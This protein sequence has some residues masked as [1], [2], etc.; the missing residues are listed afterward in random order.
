M[1][2]LGGISR[3]ESLLDFSGLSKETHTYHKRT[4][5]DSETY[6]K[7]T[8]E[9]D[10]QNRLLAQKHQVN[11][12]PVEPIVLNTYNEI[13][14]VINKKI[15][16]DDDG[17]PLQS[18]NYGYNIHGWL[19]SINDP[20]NM[21][22]DH[23]FAM[24]IKYQN[25]EDAN[26]G[27]A[28]YNGN[29]SEIDWK[30]ALGDGISRRYT[31]QYDYL[32]RL[33][34]GIYL[35]PG[36]TSNSNNH[37][38]DETVTY[39]LNGNIKTLNRYKN[40]PVGQTTPMQIDELVYDYDLGGNSNRLIKV[41]D[42]KMNPSGYPQGGNLISYDANGNMSNH[43][44]K[45]VKAI[46]YNYLN[47]ATSVNAI[48]GGFTPGMNEGT[49]HT[50]KYRADGSKYAK[51]VDNV[52]PYS[53]DYSETDYIDGFQYERTYSKMNTSQNASDS[54]YTLRSVPT[55]EGFYNFEREEYIYNL[56]DHL[57]NVRYNIARA[58]GG[59]RILME[60]TNYYPFGLKHEGYNNGS[61]LSQYGIKN[62]Y[63]YNGKELQETG[64]YDYG[65]RNYMPDLGRWGVI[66]PL[67]EKYQSFSPFNYTLNN[68]LN[69]ID[70][71]GRSVY[72]PRRGLN[73]YVDGDGIFRWNQGM[74]KY[75]HYANT[76][77]NPSV[78]NGFLGY[79][80][81]PETESSA[82]AN[83]MPASEGVVA[84]GNT[85]AV[86]SSPTVSQ[87]Q[88][89]RNLIPRSETLD[90][91]VNHP[92]TSPTMAGFGQATAKTSAR[93]IQS[94]DRAGKI[95]RELWWGPKF[96]GTFRTST[97]WASRLATTVNFTGNAVGVAGLG[98]TS[99]QYLSGQITGTEAFFDGGV[100]VLSFWCPAC[101]LIY[102]GGK[103]LYEQTTGRPAF[104]KPPGIS[105]EI[106]PLFGQPF[107]FKY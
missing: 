29:I 67:S 106:T 60:E 50:Y 1:N 81:M 82:A 28:R 102:F 44:D 77:E 103:T 32:N 64:M 66:D 83:D 75:E 90:A 80:S 7:E 87:P 9:Y 88:K 36:L 105:N 51:R 63:K 35:T 19:T 69:L 24:K 78:S 84:K 20:S 8:F 48:I 94:V 25:P 5:N 71:D 62:T 47:L 31:Y 85:P 65:A 27:I 4:A 30:T 101:G 53:T 107:I 70:P 98:F 42:Q 14:Q 73:Y 46:K 68:P 92:G 61:Y 12:K 52:N 56:K 59:G 13:G 99:Y 104:T 86:N 97:T 45:Q 23:I 37:Y 57:G 39:D 89:P 49:L 15:G 16:Q 72:P 79:Y 55:A 100:G 10:S 33:S 74:D 91:I 95:G 26:Y 18:I 40:P 41:T 17:N 54:G 38:Y 93:L 43:M 2:H 11:N 96:L 6:I 34:K 58:D 21:G 22:P 76:P 3:S